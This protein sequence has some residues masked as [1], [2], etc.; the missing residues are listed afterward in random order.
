MPLLGDRLWQTLSRLRLA[1]RTPARGMHQGE[2]RSASQGSSVEFYDYRG[3]E[4]GDDYRSIDWNIYHRLGKLLIKVFAEERSRLVHLL[5]DASASM[6]MGDPPKEEYGRRIVAALGF[7]ALS[8]GDEMQSAA[9]AEELTW[10]TPPLRGRRRVQALIESLERG[11]ARGV[12]HLARPLRTLARW[13]RRSGRRPPDL[14]ILISD[15]FD[16]EWRD[17]LEA[18][19]RR[20]GETCLIQLLSPDD[21]RPTGE[22]SF[23]IVDEETGDTLDLVVDGHALDVYAQVANDWLAEVRQACVELKVAHYVLDTTFPVDELL[24]RSFREGGLLH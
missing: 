4:P 10:R 2:N 5:L 22:G 15:L 6:K 13:S 11:E 1:T 3:Y 24:L 23:H 8:G 16:P 12:T 18:L 20:P 9:I 21:W 14:T 19:A 7:V 17:A